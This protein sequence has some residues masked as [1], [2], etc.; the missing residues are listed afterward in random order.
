MSCRVSAVVSAKTRRGTR[1]QRSTIRAITPGANPLSRVQI[2]DATS[3][4]GVGGQVIGVV[5]AGD[6][7]IDARNESEDVDI[8][9][10][11]RFLELAYDGLVLHLAMGRRA[12]DIGPVLDLVEEA[13]R[14]RRPR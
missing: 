3:G 1:P 9:T 13:V 6:A 10:L 5:S 2:A 14:R 12:D 4:D 11:A 7:S 8:D